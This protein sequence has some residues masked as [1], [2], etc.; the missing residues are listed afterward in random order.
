MEEKSEFFFSP[1]HFAE[2]HRSLFHNPLPLYHYASPFRHPFA[3]KPIFTSSSPSKVLFLYCTAERQSIVAAQVL[4]TEN[5]SVSSIVGL[6]LPSPSPEV[7][8][9]GTNQVSE[10]SRNSH[11]LSKADSDH[12]K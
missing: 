7:H 1:N 2:E 8:C 3:R 6:D 10:I 12:H 4:V 9:P 5:P 11:C